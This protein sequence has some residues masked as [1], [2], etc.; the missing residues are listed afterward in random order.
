VSGASA[1]A[2]STAASIRDI[3]DFNQKTDRKLILD[4]TFGTVD[5]KTK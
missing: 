4:S 3:F 1:L 2:R 5:A